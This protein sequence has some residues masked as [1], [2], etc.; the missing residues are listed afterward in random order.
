MS[1]KTQTT[2]ATAEG[3]MDMW[4]RHMSEYKSLLDDLEPLVF[5]AGSNSQYKTGLWEYLEAGG[6]QD[7]L[8]HDKT[9][10]YGQSDKIEEIYA[11]FAEQRAEQDNAMRSNKTYAIGAFKYK[12]AMHFGQKDRVL[13]SLGLDTSD[14]TGDLADWYEEARDAFIEEYC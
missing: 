8:V 12:M 6:N 5:S 3:F 14:L 7:Q 10:L 9:G 1:D 2:A 4:G 11:L 13:E